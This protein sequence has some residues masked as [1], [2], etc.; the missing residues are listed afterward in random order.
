MN[1]DP[2]LRCAAG[3]LAVA[4]AVLAGAVASVGAAEEAQPAPPAPPAVYT[5]F[6]SRVTDIQGDS[7]A[8]NTGRES[9]RIRLADADSGDLD[10]AQRERAVFLA[11]QLLPQEPF[12]IFPCGPLQGGQEV[13]A[14]VW[15]RKGWLAEVL[16]K[17]GLAKRVAGAPTVTFTPSAE[18]KQPPETPGPPPP[19]FAAAIQEVLSGDT[20]QTTREGRP[21]RLRLYDVTCDESADRAKDLAAQ[22]LGSEPVWIFPS[23]QRQLDG[24]DEVPVR[25][26][27]ARGWLADVLVAASLARPY[28][29]PDKALQ[30]RLGLSGAGPEPTP[31]PAS[32]PKP[33]PPPSKVVWHQV[34]VTAA[35]SDLLGVESAPFEIP[36]AEWHLAWDL[37]PV[38]KGGHINV[39]V[40]QVDPEWTTAMS[41]TSVCSF[42]GASGS[43]VVRY[44]PG[45]FWIRVTGASQLNVKVEYPE[46]ATP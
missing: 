14:R 4:A 24:G 2:L 39:S 18:A 41:H 27:T 37:K 34:T 32:G 28:P 31:G 43:G 16:I 33:A 40:F 3:A 7:F 11:A 46:P 19:A 12:W 10:A 44:P 13:R 30:E 8:Y 9:V 38:R 23:S 29:D 17:A 26:W 45:K 25:I 35:K 36:T 1:A 15:T 6:V 22:T 42:K 20:F 21:V 5:R